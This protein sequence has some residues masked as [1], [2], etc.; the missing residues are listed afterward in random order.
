[1]KRYVRITMGDH[2]GYIVEVNE[3][4]PILQEELENCDPE[5]VFTVASVELTEEEFKA[6]PE[7]EG[8]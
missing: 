1:M 4:W 7:F 8:W 2:S 5:T 3:A 6:L